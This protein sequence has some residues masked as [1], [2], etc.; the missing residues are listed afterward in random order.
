MYIRTQ[1]RPALSL[2]GI[3]EIAA[4]T[5]RRACFGAAMRRLDE[6][7]TRVAI[8]MMGGKKPRIKLSGWPNE[9]NSKQ[10]DQND[11]E[12]SKGFS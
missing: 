1:L 3:L 9:S 12:T 2:A 7:R 10:H 5:Q 11:V 8:D 4:M 6:E